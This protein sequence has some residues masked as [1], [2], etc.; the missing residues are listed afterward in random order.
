MGHTNVSSAL[1][2]YVYH[3]TTTQTYF[4]ASEPRKTLR[5][6]I[7]HKSEEIPTEGKRI[8]KSAKNTV[9]TIKDNTR[10]QHREK[11]KR[12]HTRII[13]NKTHKITDRVK[14]P[15]FC[16]RDTKRYMDREIHTK[17]EKTSQRQRKWGNR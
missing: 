16:L 13:N 15:D 10:T 8:G 14:I 17:E 9:S 12:K 2:S 4:F 3:P 6:I 11:N 7:T 1:F 5:L